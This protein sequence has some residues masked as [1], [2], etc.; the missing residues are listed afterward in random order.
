MLTGE[1][2]SWCLSSLGCRGV[3]NRVERDP[4]RES[5]KSA[6]E[7]RR[8]GYSPLVKQTRLLIFAAFGVFFAPDA[9]AQ[10]EC[11]PTAILDGNAALLGPATKLLIAKGLRV[12]PAG[13]PPGDC[14]ALN[15]RLTRAEGGYRLNIRDP[16]GRTADRFVRDLETVGTLVASWA[17]VSLVEGTAVPEISAPPVQEP[18]VVVPEVKVPEVTTA[19]TAQ[20]IVAPVAP[21]EVPVEEAPKEEAPAEIV[22]VPEASNSSAIILR[23]SGEGGVGRDRAR[24][25][26]VGL[27]ACAPISVF[28]LGVSGRYNRSD[29]ERS[30]AD[31]FLFLGLPLA[32]G[33]VTITPSVGGGGGWMSSSDRELRPLA[34]CRGRNC[35]ERSIVRG[36]DDDDGEMG[37]DPRVEARLDASIALAESFHLQ[38]G[39]SITASPS[40]DDELVLEGDPA[41]TIVRAS[42]GLV[43]GNP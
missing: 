5:K 23:L 2:V 6:K 7:S 12:E 31:G 21:V 18:A 10:S 29:E 43:W 19:T 1:L 16:W 27:S 42:A 32:M 38:L 9:L 33:P 25:A 17:N 26:G 15:V 28:C 13:L 30:A 11:A 39:G 20:P 14:P 35:A 40:L 36:D 8:G 41:N 4:S 22:P 34:R 37:L 24:W 3:G